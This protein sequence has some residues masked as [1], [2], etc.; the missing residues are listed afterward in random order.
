M[1]GGS[2][3]MVSKYKPT[4]NACKN[5]TRSRKGCF[6]LPD[7]KMPGVKCSRDGRTHSPDALCRYHSRRGKIS[8]YTVG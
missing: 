3:E 4:P 7:G 6:D 5:C 8:K 1:G 2:G